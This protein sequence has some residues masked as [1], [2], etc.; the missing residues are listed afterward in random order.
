[1]QLG[2]FSQTQLD[3]YIKSREAS[4]RHAAALS[5]TPAHELVGELVN[6]SA[7]ALA[8]AEA[9][10]DRKV[11]ERTTILGEA[12]EQ[13]NELVAHYTGEQVP[14]GAEVHWRDTSARAFSAT[15]DA[16]GK[17]THMLGIPPQ[18]LWERVPGATQDDVR[19]WKAAAEN[20]DSFRVL[21]DMLE[22]QASGDGDE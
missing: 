7:E 11:D 18:E 14:D 3:G 10:K 17:L 21:A 13:L 8:A 1:M 4:I 22:R 15:V 5:Q 12:H 16:L 6:L 9:G 20:G 19:R 2:E